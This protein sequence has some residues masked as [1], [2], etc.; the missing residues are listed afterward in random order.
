[1]DKELNFEGV[2][3]E[4]DSEAE[5]LARALLALPPEFF[6]EDGSE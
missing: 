5:E 2:M 6:E 3:G 4:L 1:M